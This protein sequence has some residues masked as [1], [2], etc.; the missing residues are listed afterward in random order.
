MR[1]WT[2]PL[3]GGA[4]HISFCSAADS[5]E[6]DAMDRLDRKLRLG[7]Y[8]ALLA[9][10]GDEELLSSFDALMREVAAKLER[11]GAPKTRQMKRARTRRA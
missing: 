3:S 2:S 11:R 4:S 6:V 1:N 5:R 7:R 8:D 9:R 10:H